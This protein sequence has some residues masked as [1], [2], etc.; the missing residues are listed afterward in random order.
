VQLLGD[1]IAVSWFGTTTLFTGDGVP[2]GVLDDANVWDLRGHRFAP[3]VIAGTV[4][5]LRD[6]DT[7]RVLDLGVGRV[8]WLATD[9]E[10]VPDVLVLQTGERLTGRDVTTGHRVW[11]LSW[12]AEHTLDLV[13]VDGMLARQADNRLTV[14]DLATGTELWHR[15]QPAYGQGMVTD[16]RRLTVIEPGPVVAAYDA[17]DGRRIWEAPVPAAVDRLAVVDHRLFAIGSEGVVAF[18]SGRE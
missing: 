9:D 5:Q 1:Q 6:V 14:V 10:S 2:A 16:G 8:P 4:S 18:G 17:R 11:R 3:E 12:S 7:G 15:T 13:I